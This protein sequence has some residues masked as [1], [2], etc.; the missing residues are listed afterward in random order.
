MHFA[1]EAPRARAKSLEYYEGGVSAGQISPLMFCRSFSVHSFLHF[2]VT[3]PCDYFCR[4]LEPKSLPVPRAAWI[5]EK[6]AS[7]L[8]G[9]EAAAV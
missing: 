1:P 5:S 4:L 3:Y 7:F 6:G 2:P 8:L 9:Q